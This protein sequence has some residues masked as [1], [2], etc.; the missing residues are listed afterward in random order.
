[1]S[2]VQAHTVQEEAAWLLAWDRTGREPFAHPAYVALFARPGDTPVALHWQDGNGEALLPLIL[3]SLP[4]EPWT[5]SLDG[6]LWNDAVSPYGYGGPF[7]SGQPDW[8]A[9]YESLLAWMRQ[10]R[11]LT[12]FIR[13]SL[14]NVPPALDVLGYEAAHLSDNIVVDLRRSEEEQWAH[15]EHKV[16]KN[17]KK[18]QR[19]ELR[20]EL[21]PDFRHLEG[22]L[23][24]YH[25]TMQRRSA[26]DWYYFEQPFFRTFDEQMRGSFLLAEVYQGDDLVSTELVLQSEQYLYSYLGGTRKDA[27]A[28]APNDLLKHAIITYGRE[29]G[30]RGYVLGGGYTPDDGIFKYKKTFDKDGVQ[31]FYGVR[32]VADPQAYRELVTAR[33][34][35]FPDVQFPAHFFPAYRAPAQPPSIEINEEA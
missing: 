20:V 29:Q 22:F 10:E 27:F 17:V 33:Q 28:H 3:R 26:G 21:H 24:I 31:P 9:F 32:L 12:A 14:E 7:S 1:M 25:S 19:A 13:A 16:R 34:A 2:A 18:A 35:H 5:K 8:G 6:R 23:D 11:V 30:K 15:Y 4:E